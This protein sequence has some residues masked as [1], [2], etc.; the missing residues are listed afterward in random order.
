MLSRHGSRFRV[1]PRKSLTALSAL[2]VTTGIAAF[3]V[4]PGTSAAPLADTALAAPPV[5]VAAP[6]VTR[7]SPAA[8]P[9][10]AWHAR[11]LAHM[12]YLKRLARE[13]AAR[14]AAAAYAA[15]HPLK[16]SRDT[17]SAPA[18]TSGPLTTAA[19][20]SLWDQAGGPSWAAPKAAEIAYCE[21][22]YNPRAYNPSGASGIWQILGQVVSGNIFDPYVNAENAVA[23]FRA[24]GDTFSAWVCQ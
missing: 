18:V 22:G 1:F 6:V 21:S 2:L 7:S 5:T 3:A 4:V 10:H 15:A 11:H 19:V 14:E 12:A 8:D 24:A 23:K 17:F 16:V 9:R 13:K 20:E